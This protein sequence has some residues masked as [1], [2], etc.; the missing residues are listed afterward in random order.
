M[1]ILCNALT[2]I[3]KSCE[4]NR[5]SVT[6]I[7]VADQLSITATTATSAN[8]ISSIALTPSEDFVEIKINRNAGN[9]TQELV[10][11]E[12]TGA[13]VV[14]QTINVTVPRLDIDKRNA[15]MLMGEGD[16]EL[17]VIVKDGNGIYWY[18]PEVILTT[19]TL[20][21][22]ENRAAG[23]SAVLAFTNPEATSYAVDVDSSI[24]AGLL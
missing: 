15:I 19:A 1:S 6:Q 22:G 10:R 13:R 5:G 2:G 18:F 23:S 12:V 16:R 21:S 8:T 9:F 20:N 11:N 3:D 7:I 24:I 17:A 14:N 4:T